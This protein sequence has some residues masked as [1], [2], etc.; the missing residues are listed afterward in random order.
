MPILSAAEVRTKEVL[1]WKGLHLYYA[2]FSLCS[3]KVMIVLELKGISFEPHVIDIKKF[4]NRSDFYLGINPR[5]LVPCLIHDGTVVIESNDILR[6]V[7]ERFQGLSLLPANDKDNEQIQSLLKLQDD[8]HMDVR[9]LTFRYVLPGLITA[10]YAKITVAKMDEEDN[11]KDVKDVTCSEGQGRVEQRRFYENLA[12]NLCVTDDDVRSSIR[13]LRR[14]L[15]SVE[16]DYDGKE[17]LV[18]DSITLID[19]AFFCDV[20]RLLTCGYPMEED[21]PNLLA[22]H[23]RIS[24]R[25]A[26]LCIP[27]DVRTF[28]RVSNPI[29]S[30]TKSTLRDMVKVVGKP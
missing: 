19:V 12:R 26:P 25:V 10:Q 28:L 14:A 21:F 20:E 29:R 15:I 27:F 11:V 5:G 6:Y 1:E 22:A 4:E 17:Y 9:N 24:G 3:R 2:E 23:G 13:N 30:L 8:Y 7:E 16:R 18:G